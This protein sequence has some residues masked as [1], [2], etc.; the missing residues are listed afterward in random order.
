[1]S[2]ITRKMVRM[3]YQSVT[4]DLLEGGNLRRS[5]GK[6]NV[7]NQTA[8]LCQTSQRGKEDDAIMVCDGAVGRAGELRLTRFGCAV[9][10]NRRSGYGR[11]HL[12]KQTN[13]WERVAASFPGSGRALGASCRYR[14]SQPRLLVWVSGIGRWP[15][16]Q[17]RP[18]SPQ[19]NGW[20][21]TA[22]SFPCERWTVRRARTATA[23][24]SL[25]LFLFSTQSHRNLCHV[26]RQ[27]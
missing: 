21:Q 24:P 10:P 8:A 17:Q 26:C 3:K 20:E 14:P 23:C 13:G 4:N 12:A 2:G 18:L 7:Q 6:S 19:R 22:A 27:P 11:R 9:K 16:S 5:C 1:M 15:L 25:C